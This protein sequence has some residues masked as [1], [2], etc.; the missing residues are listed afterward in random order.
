MSKQVQIGDPQ[1]PFDFKTSYDEEKESKFLKKSKEN[2][3]IPAGIAGA[4]FAL[5]Y[6]AIKFRSRGNQK[7]SVFLIHTRVAAQGAIVGALTVGCIYQIFHDFIWKP[8][9]PALQGKK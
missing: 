4:L 5:G 2:P 8:E 9:T 7:A 1:Q 6:A 3:F